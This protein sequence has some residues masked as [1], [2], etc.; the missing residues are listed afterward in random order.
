M[1]PKGVIPLTTFC[2]AEHPLQEIQLQDHSLGYLNEGSRDKT[3]F[4]GAYGA[5]SRQDA[6]TMAHAFSMAKGFPELYIL[7]VGFDIG[8]ALKR[9]DAYS[10]IAN[11]E[12]KAVHLGRLASKVRDEIHEYWADWV[13]EEF[14]QARRMTLSKASFEEMM[15]AT[16][17]LAVKLFSLSPELRAV[18]HPVR[19]AYGGE[20]GR[21]I[22]TVA[23]VRYEKQFI[24][25]AEVRFKSNIKL[26]I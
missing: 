26:V 6:L 17:T 10:Q 8:E 12:V 23:T 9:L 11:G 1:N 13:E 19:S 7:D 16:P 4:A 24:H 15:V 2:F 20:V 21:D 18:V 5:S 14:G 22:V 3:Y 25:S